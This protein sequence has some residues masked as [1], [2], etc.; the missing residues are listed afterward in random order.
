LTNEPHTVIMFLGILH[1]GD[2][3]FEVVFHEYGKAL[4]DIG[5]L[6]WFVPE[7]QCDDA[8]HVIGRF[9]RE[10]YRH[11]NEQCTHTLLSTAHDVNVV[12]ISLK[13]RL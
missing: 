5:S 13:V 8:V 7:R 3:D 12:I 9:E 1:E 2:D 6:D 11:V 4:W 10:K